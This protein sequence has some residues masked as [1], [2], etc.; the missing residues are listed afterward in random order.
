[1][2]NHNGPVSK[3]DVR[4]SPCDIIISASSEEGKGSGSWSCLF[5]IRIISRHQA[6]PKDPPTIV[7]GVIQESG[8]AQ[9][10]SDLAPGESLAV[11]QA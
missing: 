1:M 6:L 2:E 4:R 11:K 10:P 8:N 3:G 7:T 5:L 9:V